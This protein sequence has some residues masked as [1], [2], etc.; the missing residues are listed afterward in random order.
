MLALYKCTNNKGLKLKYQTFNDSQ[1][2]HIIKSTEN[3]YGW[4]D[5]VLSRFISYHG[6]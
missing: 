4:D 1:V 5:A 2:Q 3:M 6:T